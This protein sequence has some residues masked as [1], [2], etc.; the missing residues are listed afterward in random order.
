MQKK[1]NSLVLQACGIR[2][3]SE[4]YRKLYEELKPP[5][6]VVHDPELDDVLMGDSKENIPPKEY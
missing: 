2:N 6:N 4:T 1:W 3:A 5:P